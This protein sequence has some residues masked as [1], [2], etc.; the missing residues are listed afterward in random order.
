MKEEKILC[1][2][3]KNPL[4]NIF[5]PLCPECNPAKYEKRKYPH[6]IVRRRK[7]WKERRKAL[8]EEQDHTCQM[9]N[10]KFETHLTISHIHGKDE[11]QSGI[12][13]NVWNELMKKQ[14]DVYVKTHA[15]YYE[16][17][18]QYHHL[19]KIKRSIRFFRDKDSQKYRKTITLLKE[20]VS[21]PSYD[22]NQ[23]NTTIRRDYELSVLK[24]IRKLL[25]LFYEDIKIA[26]EKKIETLVDKYLHTK[27]V[28]VLCRRCHYAYEKGMLLCR[29]CKRNYH[30]PNYDHCYNCR[31]KNLVFCPYCQRFFTQL[32]SETCPNCGKLHFQDNEFLRAI[33]RLT[34]EQL[35]RSHYE[36][37]FCLCCHSELT[38][39]PYVYH[40][41]FVIP[42]KSEYHMGRLC[43]SCAEK[44]KK[45]YRPEKNASLQVKISS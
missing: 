4:E 20:F 2:I 9:C 37:D 18:I 34:P 17:F 25:P 39:D 40:L 6:Q 32:D 19:Q 41:F 8:L 22:F 5:L 45:S 30:R 7:Q 33:I 26:Y 1:P 24:F 16:T 36:G 28:W 35:K 44:I 21:C 43:E 29:I 15:E 13:L 31:N 11:L 10:K 3:C 27:H 38:F 14:F 42:Q 12:Y 23:W